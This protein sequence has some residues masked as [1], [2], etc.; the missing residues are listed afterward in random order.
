MSKRDS[1]SALIVFELVLTT[2]EAGF[3]FVGDFYLATNAIRPIE[4]IP[5]EYTI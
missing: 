3:C 1:A 4:I 5:A 2:R